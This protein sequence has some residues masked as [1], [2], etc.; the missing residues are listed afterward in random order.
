MCGFFVT[1][2][3]SGAG[4]LGLHAGNFSMFITARLECRGVTRLQRGEG[5]QRNCR[6]RSQRSLLGTSRVKLGIMDCTWFWRVRSS[7]Q[8]I[9]PG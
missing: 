4:L 9:A 7:G 6:Q 2:M 8:E 3:I 1:T 5:D